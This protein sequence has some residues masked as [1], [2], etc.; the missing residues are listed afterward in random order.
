[1]ATR[2]EEEPHRRKRRHETVGQQQDTPNLLGPRVARAEGGSEIE[3]DPLP[4]PDGEA[5][6]WHEDHRRQ[7]DRHL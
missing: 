7:P 4:G 5:D 3:G 1:M 2:L 6:Q